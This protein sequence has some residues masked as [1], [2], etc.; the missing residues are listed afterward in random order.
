S[1]DVC[2]SDLSEKRPIVGV[3]EGAA[4][5]LAAEIEKQ[6]TPSLPVTIETGESDGKPV[7]TI[8]VPRGQER[9]YAL[10]P[11]NILIRRDTESE[12]ATRDEIVAMVR[13]AALSAASSPH[14]ATAEPA[15]ETAPAEPRA[16]RRSSPR[17]NGRVAADSAGDRSRPTRRKGSDRPGGKPES[18]LV[19]TKDEPGAVVAVSE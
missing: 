16:G 4:E 11:G 3:E 8:T 1:S 2:S 15:K 17:T 9:P 19:A 18:A 6:V 5:A 7:L 14:G 13:D 12:I 10:A